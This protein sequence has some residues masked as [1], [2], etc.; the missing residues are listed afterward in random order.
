MLAHA[1]ALAAGL[2]LL[3]VGGDVLIR[4]ASALATRLGLSPVVVGLTVVA[5]GTSAPELVVCLVAARD[6][7][8]GIA[9]GNVVGSNIA[10]LGLLLGAT[11]LV[12]PM[13][14]R[15]TLVAREIPM[16]VL[17]SAA[18]VLVALDVSLDGTDADVVRRTDGGLLL[19]FFAVFLYATA[20]D[21][22]RARRSDPV[23]EGAV[24]MPPALGPSPRL[25]VSL[26][27][28]V[29]GLAGLTFGGRL[30]V[31]SVSA[32]AAALG[33]P[34]VVIGAT[35]VAVGTSLPEL[36]TSLIAAR[37]G[38]SDLAVGNVVGSNIFNLL[39]VLGTT[40]VVAPVAV[41]DGGWVDLA[42]MAGTA[43]LVLPLAITHGHRITRPEGGLLLLAYGGY[44]A[45][46]LARAT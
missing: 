28:V 33:V 44:V 8:P 26:V 16:M 4:G 2:V 25:A 29:A 27:L 36:A 9:F 21:V 14:I 45:W 3:L 11:A 1:L 38:Q 23:L 13:A 18:G 40:A 35:V 32:I 5:F 30:T 17:A 7:D 42:F 37:R 43:L 12:R 10:N 6:G 31:S 46:Q 24:E 19:L 39:F 22:I 41:P 15:G 34:A 20:A